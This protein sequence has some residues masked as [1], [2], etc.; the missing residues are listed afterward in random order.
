[1]Q[2]VLL[3]ANKSA[4]RGNAADLCEKSVNSCADPL[5]YEVKNPKTITEMQEVCN[6]IEPDTYK[7]VFFV[8]GDGTINQALPSLLGRGIPLG[9][10]P[11][12]TANDLANELG[13]SFN[14]H[15][16][17]KLLDLD[18]TGSVDVIRMNSS[19]FLTVGG[20]GVGALLTEEFN[21]LRES[22]SL[23][24][25][26]AR[27]LGANIYTVLCVKTILATRK[28]VHRLRVKSDEFSG[29][30]KSS[31]LFV[32]N[33]KKLGHSLLVAP[34]AVIDDGVFEVLI[35]TENCQKRL[36][37]SLFDLRAGRQPKGSIH[38]STSSLVVEDM[39][40]RLIPVFGDGETLT[41]AKRLEFSIVPSALRMFRTSQ[42]SS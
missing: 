1:M 28:Y 14:H 37:Q 26:L 13:M 4:G 7:G 22:S 16:L 10:L 39:D 27:R 25:K 23:F 3:I 18:C 21:R 34:S 6:A 36:I 11:G 41:P 24:R 32:C 20:L 2:R 9:V 35:L 38:F 5:F 15:F 17:T 8:G 31:A 40:Q 30:V 29:E 42:V 33:Q 19:L 12:G